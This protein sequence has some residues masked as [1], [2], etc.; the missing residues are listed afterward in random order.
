VDLED[1]KWSV[2]ASVAPGKNTIFVYVGNPGKKDLIGNI[3]RAFREVVDTGARCRL[4]VAGPSR[5]QLETVLE[6]EGIGRSALNGWIDVRGNLEQALVPGVLAPADFSVLA[7]PPLRYAMAGFPTKVVE[8]LAAGTPPLLNVTSDL[9][10]IIRDGEN[11]ILARDHS[12]TALTEA[13]GRGIRM[14]PGARQQMRV[15]ARQT[16]ETCFDFRRFIKP[17]GEFLLQVSKR[18]Q[19]KLLAGL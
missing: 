19:Q 14:G 11:G 1:A 5:T 16:A 7:R 4:I 9:G 8:S 2:P 17:L 3:L 15:R 13:I 6:R 12:V 10:E 18:R